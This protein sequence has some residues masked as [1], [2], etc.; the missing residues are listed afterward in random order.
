MK[1]L[2][3]ECEPPARGSQMICVESPAVGWTALPGICIEINR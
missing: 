3:E 2:V 1:T